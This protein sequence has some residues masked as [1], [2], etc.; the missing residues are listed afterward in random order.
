M[1]F[2]SS[3]LKLCL[4]LLHPELCP[5]KLA[6]YDDLPNQGSIYQTFIKPYESLYKYVEEKSGMK[7]R[8]PHQLLEF[9]FVVNTEEDLHLN[10][11]EWVHKVYPDQIYPVASL[12]Y[13]YHNMDNEI[14]K[15]N[16]GYLMKKILMDA[17]NMTEVPKQEGVKKLYLYSGHESTLG[18]LLFALDV[19]K[20]HI[21]A[22]G[23][24][25][26]IELYKDKQSEYFIKVIF[27]LLM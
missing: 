14:K 9:Y 2:S 3:M 16:A 17:F 11:P 18:Y 5:K 8:H 10:L 12:T 24:A 25:I 19:L 7:I 27:N 4:Q 20:P 26:M 15:I 13:S 1:N 22:Y 6:Y 21:P 23:S